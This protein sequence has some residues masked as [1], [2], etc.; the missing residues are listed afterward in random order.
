V[1]VERALEIKRE[2][3]AEVKRKVARLG[4]IF[5]STVAGVEVHRRGAENA[6]GAQRRRE[7]M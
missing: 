3:G 7:T 6:E 2:N 5:G 4:S 1:R